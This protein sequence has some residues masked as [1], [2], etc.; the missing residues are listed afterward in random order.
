MMVVQAIKGRFPE[1]VETA[2]AYCALI[3][4][5]DDLA[6]D[7]LVESVACLLPRLHDA[8]R[9]LPKSPTDGPLH[10]LVDLETRFAL[11]RRIHGRL[12]ERDAYWMAHDY[13]MS[14]QIQS[15]SLADDL[16]DIYFDL[17]RGLQRLDE[18]TPAAYYL[19]LR[20][21]SHSYDLHWGEHLADAERHVSHLLELR[22]H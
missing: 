10:P 2:R 4:G 15:G 12:G 18:G 9:S 13:V 14:G 6:A 22:T 3:E 1:L 17:R 7:E 21:W 8:V 5:I 19:A 20:D 16:T 11:Y